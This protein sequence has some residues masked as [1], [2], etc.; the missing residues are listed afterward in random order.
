M[1]GRGK[2]TK[3]KKQRK[4]RLSAL[5]RVSYG[6]GHRAYGGGQ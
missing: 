1:D 2:Q 4:K 5:N 3:K 6:V